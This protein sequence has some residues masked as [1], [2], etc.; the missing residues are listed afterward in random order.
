LAVPSTTERQAREDRRRRALG[1]DLTLHA[2][3]LALLL[4]A[5]VG[6]DVLSPGPYGRFSRVQK[7]NDFVQFY[8][9][10]ALVRLGEFKSLVDDARFRQAQRPYLAPAA[11]AS[12]PA[13]YGPQVAVGLAP[14][15]GLPYLGAFVCW[16]VITIA[17]IVWAVRR[18]WHA[19]P[20][21]YGWWR[22]VLAVTAAFPPFAYLVLAGQ[23]SVVAVAALTLVVAGLSRGSKALAGGALGILGYKVSLL[24]PAIAVCVLAGEG[25]MVLVAVSVVI[26]QL[27]AVIPIVGSDV[28]GAFIS[29]TLAV[30][31]APDTL[32]ATP[33]LMFSLRTFWSQLLPPGWVTA[34]Y[35][36]SMVLTWALTA[37]GWRRTADPLGRVALLAISAALT[38]PH[39]YL[40]DLVVLIPAFIYAGGI[41][42]ERRVPFLRWTT[43]LAFVSPLASPPIAYWTH[44][45]VAT[46]VLVAWLLAL[47]RGEKP[48]ERPPVLPR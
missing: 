48:L 36:F 7:G 13:L 42:V 16:S 20:A 17:G 41:L 26:L 25:T 22:P 39:L 28:V 2:T 24:V 30:G 8:T 15:A 19:C 43:T 29:N 35:G 5:A 40:Y 37:W 4:W 9:L 23:L 33:V 31:R 6:A 18:C 11:H 3:L 45:Q 12:Y 47:V 14:L 32:A 27:I 34:V 10:A 46:L 38:A 1:R 21:L 44:V